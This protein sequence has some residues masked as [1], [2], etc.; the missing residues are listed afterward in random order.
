MKDRIYDA[1]K[2]SVLWEIIDEALKDL[3]E[4]KDLIEQTDHYYVVGYLV[5]KITESK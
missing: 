1:Y 4:N 3:I 5:K 2:D